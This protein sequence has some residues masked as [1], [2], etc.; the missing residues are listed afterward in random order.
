LPS[1]VFAPFEDPGSESFNASPPVPNPLHQHS[2]TPPAPS[3]Q[4]MPPP[5]PRNSRTPPPPPL[6]E[7]AQLRFFLEAVAPILKR[8]SFSSSAVVGPP[9][10]LYDKYFPGGVIFFPSPRPPPRRCPLPFITPANFQH[11]SKDFLHGKY[12]NAAK[13]FVTP[14]VVTCLLPPPQSPSPLDIVFPQRCPNAMD[15]PCFR[16]ALALKTFLC[17]RLFFS[18][19]SPSLPRWSPFSLY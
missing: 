8:P 2:H 9:R 14:P 16:L 1:G 7:Q 17:L 6:L 12:R 3:H 15:P 11:K 4:G 5:P 18:F 19:P 13:L 10:F